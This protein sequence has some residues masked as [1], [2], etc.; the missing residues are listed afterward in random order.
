MKL[1]SVSHGHDS[2]NASSPGIALS[3]SKVRPATMKTRRCQLKWLCRVIVFES[4][5]Q[6]PHQIAVALSA[7]SSA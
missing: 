6:A 1:K 2:E 7:A 3:A 5:A 4:S